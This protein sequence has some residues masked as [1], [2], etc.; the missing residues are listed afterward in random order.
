[1]PEP[2]RENVMIRITVLVLWAALASTA[3]A[4]ADGGHRHHDAHQ[5]GVARLTVGAE[6]AGVEVE[7][8]SPAA[9]LVGF[10]HRP[11]DAAEAAAVEAA[12]AALREGARLFQLPEAAG[13][14]LHGAEVE[15]PLAAGTGPGHEHEHEHEHGSE[16]PG[17]ADVHARYRFRCLH[18]RQLTH[19]R[20]N[21]FEAFPATARV[22]AEYATDRG[23]GAARL[24][25]DDPVLR[26]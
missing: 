24:T 14:S 17:H 20:V 15:T 4:A 22:E 5:H 1:M 18:P 6:G 2:K 9:N 11:R 3:A 23:Q 8:T 7:L 13:C 26:F 12:L 19:L 21:L 10:E 16:H 25:A